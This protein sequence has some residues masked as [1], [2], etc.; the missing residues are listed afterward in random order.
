MEIGTANTTHEKT[1]MS[2]NREKK[3]NLLQS[4]ILFSFWLKR[5][6][7]YFN[8]FCLARTQRF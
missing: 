3:S 2:G 5:E 8:M 6:M 4:G 7:F 1:T